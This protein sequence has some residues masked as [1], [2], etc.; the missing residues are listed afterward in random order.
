MER[1]R[2]IHDY[3]G[4][5]APALFQEAIYQ[6]LSNHN[7]AADYTAGLRRECFKH[8]LYLKGEL[9][10]MSFFIPE[11]G[12]GY[13]L[14]ARLPQPFQDGYHFARQLLEKTGVGV[15][16]GENFSPRSDNYIRLNFTVNQ[17]LLSQAVHLLGE[18]LASD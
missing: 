9:E 6:Y 18:F 15:V 10:K 13:F 7:L 14:W 11:S 8:F 3:V 17:S 5:C 16:P 12:G 1:I 4:L 2:A